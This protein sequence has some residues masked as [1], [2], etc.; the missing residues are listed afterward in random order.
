MKN[1]ILL[2]VILV[3]VA[4]VPAS[5]ATLQ[6]PSPNYPTIQAAIDD[7][8][9]GDT[10]TIAPGRYL[11]NLDFQGK[12]I[13]V[14]SSNPDD[15]N[16]VKN[17]IIDGSEGDP[18]EIGSCVVFDQNEG[19]GSIL[20]GITLTKGTGTY[21]AYE[22]RS[23]GKAPVRAGGGILCL[24][25]SPTIRRCNITDNG[26]KGEDRGPAGGGIAL[27]GNCQ[28]TISNCLI[29]NNEGET[30]LGGGGGGILISSNTP[31][32]AATTI[33]NCTILN[34]I[35]DAYEFFQRNQVDC[36]DTRPTI[37]NTIIWESSNIDNRSLLISDPCL[38]TYSCVRQAYI[39]VGRPPDYGDDPCDLTSAGGNISADPLL[40]FDSH[41]QAGSPCINTGDPN[42]DFTGLADI[43]GEPR[44]M[45]ARVDM[46]IDEFLDTDSDG[47]PDWW[48]TKYFAS[49]TA[50]N[51]G[52]DPD[53][54]GYNNLAE[55]EVSTNPALAG[56]TYYADAENG[57]D[58][59]DGLAPE[60]DG[61]HGPKRTIQAAI[62]TATHADTVIVAQG[63]YLENVDYKGKA[64]TVRSTNPRDWHVV[65]N[66]VIDG[67]ESGYW[68]FGSCVTFDDGETSNSI[69]DGITLTRGTG[70]RAYYAEGRR[71]GRPP[72]LAGGGVLCLHSSPTIRNCNITH[73]GNRDWDPWG[74]YDAD[75]WHGGGI[76]IL[77]NCQA[78]ITSCVIA[79]NVVRKLGAGILISSNLPQ[80]A[81][82]KIIN[83]TIANNK[84]FAHGPEER[85][86][87]DCWNTNP[88]ISNTIIWPNLD[89]P[90]ED[91]GYGSGDYTRSLLIADASLVT[92]SC[93]K[94]AYILLEDD[95]V[96]PGEGYWGAEPCDLTVAGG[97]IA[98]G[99]IFAQPFGV[100]EED[101]WDSNYLFPDYHVVRHSPC[102]NAGDPNF[103]PVPGETDID[104]QAR[105]MGG[106]VDMGTDE[107]VPQIV[108]TAPASG[109]VWT[110]GSTHQVE[111]SSYGAGTVNILYSKDGGSN[112]QTIETGAADTGSYAWD[113]A[114]RIHSDQSVLRVVP[115]VPDDSV[116]CVDSGIFTIQS[117]RGPV[118][119]PR[120]RR[121]GPKVGEKYGPEF[122][123]VKWT[124]ETGGPVTAAVTLGRKIGQKVKAYVACEDGK[125][126]TLD[127]DTGVLLWSYDTNSPLLASAAEGWHQ[128][129]YVAATNG[130]LYALDKQ[131][132]LLW[133]HTTKKPLYSSPVATPNGRIYICS[134]DGTL[135]ALARDGS[136]LW[137]FRPDAAGITDGSI[138]ATPAIGTDGTVYV[139]GLRD[140]N[141]YAL[142]PVDGSVKWVCNFEHTI[143]LYNP[144]DPAGEPRDV[145]IAGWPFASPVVAPDG[146]IYQGLL[147][148]T[149]LFALEPG[150][151][152]NWSTDL[153]GLILWYGRPPDNY[154]VWYG[155]GQPPEYVEIDGQQRLVRI[156]NPLRHA[157]CW[158][159][160][161]LGP[162]GTI[163]VSFNDPYLRAVDPNGSIKW[164]TE[165]GSLGGFTMTVGDD[166]PIY[167]ASDDNNLY[168]V[169]PAG[170]EV[171]R[172]QGDDWLSHPVI[173]PDG[174]LLVSDANNTVWA[175]SQQA[176]DGQEPVLDAP[177]QPDPNQAEPVETV[178]S[179]GN[180]KRK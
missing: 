67:S 141:L 177:Q 162:D 155:A 23:V 65:K 135:Y 108:V 163:Y 41:L 106:R 3:L 124:F 165:L 149:Y 103:A 147:F 31:E 146:V 63:L 47:L 8:N 56:T 84:S 26:L 11:E 75:L 170:E 40:T 1:A 161:A 120:G 21:A 117:Y 131:G 90:P 101:T 88:V 13:T 66:T 150:G 129:V 176:C 107:V 70:T 130:K 64:I 148:D 166:G 7:A 74:P 15:W 73:N 100:W 16:V 34:N 168:V 68:G 156:V 82:S 144:E 6:V 61:E 25:S 49:S 154:I 44:V 39:Y 175:I 118:S 54:D 86:E 29:T 72:I 32:T 52:D 81:T 62:D 48:E 134:Q 105:I 159:T 55:Y 164:M 99:P 20:D 51:P 45:G 27:L 157:S 92:Y 136:E 137:S 112:W 85:Y 119:L 172:F 97:N 60:F 30:R 98:K 83:C 171:A 167:A 160:P 57:D 132:H 115:G 79:D 42:G 173:A 80:T 77:G 125:L 127:A 9:H 122:G 143:Q 153:A 78:T 95:S 128:A 93:V 114:N 151:T 113:I 109:D 89:P 35:T 145:N 69:L 140:P 33:T 116:I 121:R 58:S 123:C 36:W 180:S 50:A 18:W 43:D 5:A 104:G 71:L 94:D 152:I 169:N 24:H 12:A 179:K 59:Y 28:A 22:H 178:E 133:T 111:W 91:D 138:F 17:T 174:T 142:N 139:G 38:V 10:V 2:T 46:G 19:T 76:A 96:Y 87:V 4:S 53:G 37:S 102:I 158:S 110:S 126:Y 14:R